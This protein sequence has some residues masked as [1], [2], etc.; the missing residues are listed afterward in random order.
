M[1]RAQPLLSGATCPAG[2]KTSC[3]ESFIIFRQNFSLRTSLSLALSSTL[4][5][6]CTSAWAAWVLLCVFFSSLAFYQPSSFSSF[7]TP[8]SQVPFIPV[9]LHTALPHIRLPHPLF[10]LLSLDTSAPLI[11]V[12]N[13][14]SL[15]TP[16]S[17][18]ALSLLLRVVPWSSST[19]L[20][21]PLFPFL[22]YFTPHPIFPRL[23]SSYRCSLGIISGISHSISL[24]SLCFIRSI[25]RRNHKTLYNTDLSIWHAGRSG[26]VLTVYQHMGDEWWE[27]FIMWD[28]A[29]WLTAEPCA[30]VWCLE[31][32][33]IVL[34]LHQ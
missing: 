34:G 19:Q 29:G 12:F 20:L 22:P 8:P 6:S 4:H 33:S 26:V 13:L 14:G 16:L 3:C 21:L 10:H 15:P 23:F 2:S 24:L 5:L 30:F 17:S 31:A 7:F 28:A 11:L 9:L 1:W 32:L 27:S 18:S 25:G